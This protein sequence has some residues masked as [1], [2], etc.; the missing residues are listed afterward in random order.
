M[1]SGIRDDTLHTS[2]E[3]KY[4]GQEMVLEIIQNITDYIDDVF[5]TAVIFPAMGNHDY[6]PK[7]QIP[8]GGSPIVSALAEMWKRWLSDEAY[9]S[10]K[11]GIVFFM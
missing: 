6:H 1:H 3:T 9:N 7:N 10:F 8:P 4:L 5:P 11:K 2:N